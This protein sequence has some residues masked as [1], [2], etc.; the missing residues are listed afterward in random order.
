MSTTGDWA[1]KTVGFGVPV[2]CAA[3]ALDVGRG[4]IAVGN[5]VVGLLVVLVVIAVG[6][7]VMVVVGASVGL[8]ACVSVLSVG[9]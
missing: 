2:G 6:E 7:D 1:G 9:V 5:S 3:G 4:T 8:N